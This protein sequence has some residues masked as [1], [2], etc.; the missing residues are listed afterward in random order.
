MFNIEKSINDKLDSIAESILI[1]LDSIFNGF[2]F[3]LLDFFQVFLLI[4]IFWCCYC[5]MMHR[6][7][8]SIPPF[9]SAKPLDGLFFNSMFY[10]VIAILK[11][12]YQ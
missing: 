11:T 6:D 5:I 9:S 4:Y 7:K 8:L 10:F 1:K 2:L 12:K 3:G